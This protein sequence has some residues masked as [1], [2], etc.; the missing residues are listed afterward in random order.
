MIKSL[1][2]G[3][4]FFATLSYG[5]KKTLLIE[6][7][8]NNRNG[9]DLGPTSK[10]FEVKIEKRVLHLEK[11][12]KNFDNRSCLW[13]SKQV[14]GFD[15]SKNFSIVVKAKHITNGDFTDVL[16]IQWGVVAKNNINKNS[17]LYQLNIFMSGEVRLD[18]FQKKWDNFNKV[19]IKK[20]LVEM[21]FNPKANNRY[22]ILQEN[23]FVSLKI[24]EKEVYRQY[25][26]PIE[27]SSIG[28]QHCL[29]GAWEIDQI[30]VSHLLPISEN[31]VKNETNSIK[32]K[33]VESQIPDTSTY[34]NKIDNSPAKIITDDSA[35]SNPIAE[36]GLKVF[37]KE[38]L[39][40]YPNPFKEAFNVK[41]NL[42]K[43]GSVDLYIFSIT[44]LLVKTENKYFQ[45]GEQ[46]FLVDLNVPIG[47]YIVRVVTKNNGN[48]YKRII[49]TEN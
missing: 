12:H 31:I 5:Q 8:D 14:E 46:S 47:V 25:V 9:W 42:D 33:L 20:K 11:F 24:N 43:D 6:N 35:I 48:L 10:E 36:Q 3:M 4:L 34:L 30:V 40:I 41:F 21:N 45:K 27:G 16:D 32:I 1:I 13:Y 7:F 22:E 17:M 37:E 23:A 18:F 39:V 49:R 15:A 26:F 2:L 38:E 28:F 19:N 29:K 44:G